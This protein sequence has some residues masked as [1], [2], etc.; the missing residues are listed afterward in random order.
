[1]SPRILTLAYH[2]VTKAQVETNS[3]LPVLPRISSFI[4]P[5]L[6]PATLATRLQTSQPLTS[7]D[8]TQ[9]TTEW[10]Q[11]KNDD[12]VWI[13]L[14][15]GN[16]DSDSEYILLPPSGGTCVAVAALVAAIPGYIPVYGLEH[17]GHSNSS[18]QQDTYWVQ[19]LARLYAEIVRKH[20]VTVR[21]KK[22]T[23]VGASFGA[24]VAAEMVLMFSS[25]LEENSILNNVQLVLLD[26]PVAGYPEGSN[27]SKL[28]GD[29]AREGPN[30][31]HSNGHRSPDQLAS[32]ENGLTGVVH[33]QS[34]QALYRY[35]GRGV[36]TKNDLKVIYVAARA[37]TP[38]ETELEEKRLWW[39]RIFPA[40]RWEE[41]LATHED[42]W[43]AKAADVLK[44]L[45]G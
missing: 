36:A 16:R 7:N 34:I 20:L 18:L 4:Q 23:I 22:I 8:L 30:G 25:W 33:R 28:N 17:P 38:I 41:L 14:Q 43:Q 27:L 35:S 12:S 37:E 44:L 31:I 15:A 42:L 2:T 13:E 3:T 24:I 39:T 1:M 5:S 26:A 21:G 40:M 29:H 19:D 32:A 6:T 10:P 45:Q 9:S 11:I